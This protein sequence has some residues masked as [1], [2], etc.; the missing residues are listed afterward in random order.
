MCSEANTCVPGRVA[1]GGLLGL[2][3]LTNQSVFEW[4]DLR[5]YDIRELEGANGLSA[6]TSGNTCSQHQSHKPALSG[7]MGQGE[8]LSPLDDVRKRSAFEKGEVSR[9]NL[10]GQ[11]V[12]TSIPRMQSGFRAS[13]L[14]PV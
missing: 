4:F 12:V 13:G 10:C 14:T 5:S 2:T 3:V 9:T 8:L 1:A 6:H 11:L 7:T